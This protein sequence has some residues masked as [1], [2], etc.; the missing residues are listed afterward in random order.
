MSDEAVSD[1]V[2]AIP[3]DTVAVIL[4]AGAG[5]RFGGDLHKLLAPLGTTSVIGSALDHV[6]AAGFTHV[7]VVTGAVEL[8]DSVLRDPRLVP[9]HN[10]RWADGQSTSLRMG[11]EAAR[12][13]GA[14]VVIVGLGDQPFIDPQA[15]RLVAG[16][17]SPIAFAAY[18]GRRGHPVRLERSVWSSL[19]NEGDV[20]A[21]DLIL[22][23]PAKVSQVDCP[24]SAM[25][26][27]TQEDLARWT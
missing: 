5:S 22:L 27:D 18:A 19:P 16:A 15:W 20:G 8:P 17:R 23:S 7:V 10:A 2:R 24:G 3:D 25:D 13:L 9:V 12:N 4:A 6:L 26:I 21:R 1:S 14:E 11:I